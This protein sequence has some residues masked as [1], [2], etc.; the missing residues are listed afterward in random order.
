MDISFSVEV[1]W[2]R[3]DIRTTAP[4]LESCVS[5]L[6]AEGDLALRS[7]KRP[8]TVAGQ[9]WNCTNFAAARQLRPYLTSKR[10]RRAEAQRLL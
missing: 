5:H 1:V 6:L 2:R 10:Q 9:R 4:Y 7:P 8:L 3:M